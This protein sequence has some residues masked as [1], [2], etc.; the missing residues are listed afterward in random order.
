MKGNSERGKEV[1]VFVREEFEGKKWQTIKVKPVQSEI[2]RSSMGGKR[3]EFGGKERQTL[4][5]GG[6]CTV[7]VQ[8]KMKGKSMGEKEGRVLREGS[9]GRLCRLELYYLE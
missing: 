9:K 6:S 5:V 1:G 8:H 3:V 4:Y 2:E 7:C